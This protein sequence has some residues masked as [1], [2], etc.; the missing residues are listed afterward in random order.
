MD[1]KLITM[2]LAVIALIATIYFVAKA[3]PDSNEN[4]ENLENLENNLNDSDIESYSDSEELENFASVDSNPQAVDQPSQK[5]VSTDNTHKEIIDSRNIR[6]NRAPNMTVPENAATPSIEA[7]PSSGNTT[8]TNWDGKRTNNEDGGDEVLNAD[9]SRSD[10]GAENPFN[11]ENQDAI[12]EATAVFNYNARE[13]EYKKMRDR[14]NNPDQVAQDNEVL[15][16]PGTDA[17]SASSKGFYAVSSISTAHKNQSTDLRGEPNVKHDS[18]FF[19]PFNSS[20][21]KEDNLVSKVS[22]QN[23][24]Q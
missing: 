12:D 4:L 24:C 14:L 6:V 18:N 9:G 3:D 5:I 10:D 7:G 20:S 2:L 17:L 13:E 11:E 21:W 19:A 23:W 22:N 16:L 8:V 15:T 1:V